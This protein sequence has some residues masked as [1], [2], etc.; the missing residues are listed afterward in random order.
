MFLLSAQNSYVI[1]SSYTEGHVKKTQVLILCLLLFFSLPK[2]RN[3]FGKFNEEQIFKSFLDRNNSLK[4]PAFG[5]CDSVSYDLEESIGF[6]S[7]ISS[8]LGL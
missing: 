1:L 8:V 7:L 5:F 3:F 6:R 2:S 4:S